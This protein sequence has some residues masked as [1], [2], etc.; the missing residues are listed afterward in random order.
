MSRHLFLIGLVFVKLFLADPGFAQSKD[1]AEE[2]QLC[3]QEAKVQNPLVEEAEQ[4]LFT[5]RRVEI[6]GNT[7]IRHRE[8]VKRLRRFNEGDIFTRK[9]FEKS[10]KSVSNMRSIFPITNEN[11]EIRLDREHGDV[12]IVFCVK[13]RP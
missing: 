3:G 13:Q 7:T 12:D 4:K 6:V 10:V 9:S 8:F 5:I 11:A 1:G 2:Q